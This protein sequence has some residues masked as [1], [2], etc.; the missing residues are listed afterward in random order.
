[1]TNKQEDIF[2]MPDNKIK[3]FEQGAPGSQGL[4]ITRKYYT[5]TLPDGKV[6]H[7]VQHIT[8][9]DIVPYIPEAAGNNTEKKKI[10]AVLIIP[11]GALKVKMLP[12]GLIVWE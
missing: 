12:S 11:G 8:D 7:I 3:L 6:K 4:K 5:E 10:P 9:P 1:M 2:R